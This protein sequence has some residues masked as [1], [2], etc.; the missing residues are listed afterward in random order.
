MTITGSRFSIPARSQ[1]Q[2]LQL[3]GAAKRSDGKCDK[4]QA[5]DDGNTDQPVGGISSPRTQR[6]VQPA[7]GQE[8]K[9]RADGLME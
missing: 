7:E 1:A 6:H 3:P 8:G 5:N 4:H 2:A 9:N